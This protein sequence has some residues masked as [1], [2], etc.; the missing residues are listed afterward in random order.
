MGL[1][2]GYGLELGSSEPQGV[3][4]KVFKTSSLPVHHVSPNGNVYDINFNA[5]WNNSLYKTNSTVQPLSLIIQ[6]L[7]KY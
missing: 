4:R 2:Y 1:F 6:Y 3:F 5:Q 7:I